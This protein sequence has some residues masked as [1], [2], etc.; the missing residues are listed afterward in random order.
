MLEADKNTSQVEALLADAA[1]HYCKTL[2]ATP[3]AISYLA[4]RGISGAIAGRFG[5]GYADAGWQSLGEIF[6]QY[7]AD[8]VEHSGL[9][10]ASEGRRFDRFRERVMFPIKNMAGAVVGFGGRVT[11]DSD[12]AKYINSP[13]GPFFKKRELLYGIHEAKRAIE[14]AGYSIVVEGYLDVVALAQAGVEQAVGTLGTAC[15][16]IHV[17]ELLSIAPRIVFCF[18]GDRAGRQAAE[19]AMETVLPFAVD[20][21]SFEFV[22]LPEGHDPD[23]FVRKEGADGLYG[24][25]AGAVSLSRLLQSKVVAGC[26]LRHA[27]DRA[28]CV[29]TA[30]P[31]WKALPKGKTR[32][33]LLAFCA[34]MS[35]LT[36]DE[37]LGIWKHHRNTDNSSNIY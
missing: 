5:I 28:R 17:L 23:S 27:E 34:Q 22:F 24:A 7:S 19:R 35:G 6:S 14:E 20:V 18:D 3:A 12:Q 33:E 37:I 25:L 8:T 30:E 11:G 10:V 4:Q 32:S 16:Q 31:Y 9:A 13:E 26:D 1:E 15:S 21:Q 29:A 36:T 2:R